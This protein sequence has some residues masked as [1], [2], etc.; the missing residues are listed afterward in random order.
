MY[1]TD[2]LLGYSDTDSDRDSFDANGPGYDSDTTY[3]EYYERALCIPLEIMAERNHM[4][5]GFMKVLYDKGKEL[6]YWQLADKVLHEKL[7]QAV[8]E[9][10]DPEVYDPEESDKI[11][12][13]TGM[14]NKNRQ[15]VDLYEGHEPYV[16]GFIRRYGRD[17][18]IGQE[19]IAQVLFHQ[20]YGG[21]SFIAQE[22]EFQYF[23]VEILDPAIEDTMG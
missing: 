23:G 16:S 12:E 7:D 20:Y 1:T 17:N 18:D 13:I 8:D 3:E 11:A 22:N 5:F 10:Y 4:V 21:D 15:Y 6:G 9:V 19:C 14:M 2:D